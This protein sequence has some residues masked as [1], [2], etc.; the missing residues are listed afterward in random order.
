M[1]S[2]TFTEWQNVKHQNHNKHMLK[3]SEIAACKPMPRNCKGLKVKKRCFKKN[4][5]TYITSQNSWGCFKG[6][7][8]TLPKEKTSSNKLDVVAS[9][10]LRSGARRKGK[11]DLP[12]A[13]SV[14]SSW[15]S[16]QY[17]NIQKSVKHTIVAIYSKKVEICKNTYKSCSDLF[18]F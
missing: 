18:M 9:G 5:A 10:L 8:P 7:V 12:V 4:S 6:K 2:Y 14:N 17:K 1:E 15:E 3:I 13:T 16:R 11:F